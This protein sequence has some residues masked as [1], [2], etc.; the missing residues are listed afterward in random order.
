MGPV[1][2]DMY[3]LLYLSTRR[4]QAPQK[5][6]LRSVS[7]AILLLRNQINQVPVLCSGCCLSGL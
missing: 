3:S 2:K 7:P 1:A 4:T 6:V 5:L